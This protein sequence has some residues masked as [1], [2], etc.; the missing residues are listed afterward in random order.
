MLRYCSWATCYEIS[1]SDLRWRSGDVPLGEAMFDTEV[2]VR[3]VHGNTADEGVLFIGATHAFAK[4]Y[5][6]CLLKYC[7]FFQEAAYENVFLMTKES[8]RLAS[9]ATAVTSCGVTSTVTC[10][11]SLALMTSSSVTACASVCRVWSGLRVQWKV[12]K[13]L[14]PCG[15]NSPTFSCFSNRPQTTKV[16]C[17]HVTLS[18][19]S[20]L[21]CLHS[22]DQRA[23]RVYLTFR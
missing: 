3:D 2:E 13:Q 12:L 21:I 19:E 1:E 10:T 20:K 15:A 6:S 7:V 16:K 5:N 18:I 17:C 23:S 14:S 11:S 22:I 8:L 9:C 4:K